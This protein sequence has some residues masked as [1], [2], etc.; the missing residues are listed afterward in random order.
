MEWRH[1]SDNA[2]NNRD[3]GSRREFLRSGMVGGSFFGLG[4]ALGWFAPNSSAA[5]KTSAKSG[6]ALSSEFVYDAAKLQEVDAKLIHYEEK[7]SIESGLKELRGIAVNDKGIFVVGDQQLAIFDSAGTSQ[8]RFKVE[9]PPRCVAVGPE[10][11]LYVG[12]KDFVGVYKANG[13]LERQW[14]RLRSGAVI[15]SIAIGQAEAFVADAGNRAILRYELDGRQKGLIGKKELAQKKS[16]FVIPSPYFD[17][18]LGPGN[19]LWVANTGQHL[20]EAYT[21]EGEKE[22]SWGKS[23]MGVAGFCG[24]CNPAHFALLPDGRFVTSEKGLAR[25]KVYSPKGDFESVVAPPNCFPQL[26]DSNKAN[27][28]GLDVAVDAEGMIY[29][30]ESYSGK[31]RRFVKKNQFIRAL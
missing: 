12:F 29:V 4:S 15:T 25:I 18:A 27:S 8:A 1:M 28:T 30:A 13:I 31:I 10:G 19:L 2:E 23:S 21:M 11:R 7:P 26:L 3:Q 22:F 24:C 6:R 20:V 17:V 5:V 14:G 9:E 16:H